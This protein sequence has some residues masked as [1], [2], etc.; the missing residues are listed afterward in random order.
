MAEGRRGLGRGLSALLG[1]SEEIAHAADPARGQ[2][3]GVRGKWNIDIGRAYSANGVAIGIAHD[4][5]LLVQ[6]NARRAGRAYALVGPGKQIGPGPA[7]NRLPGK[8]IGLG[9]SWQQA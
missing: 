9:A 8:V 6:R 1:D 5:K 3:T 2:I 4:F 7:D